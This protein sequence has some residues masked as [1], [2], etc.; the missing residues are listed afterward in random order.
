MRHR[1]TY[2]RRVANAIAAISESRRSRSPIANRD[3][4]PLAPPMA[5]LMDEDRCRVT[6]G[7]GVHVSLRRLRGAYTPRAPECRRYATSYQPPPLPSAPNVYPGLDVPATRAA[8]SANRSRVRWRIGIYRRTSLSPLFRKRLSLFEMLR[9]ARGGNVKRKGCS[10]EIFRA[11]SVGK[12]QFMLRVSLA[13][14]L[15]LSLLRSRIRS[16]RW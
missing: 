2:T 9:E 13:I 15:S 12:F 7:H 8:R 16:S 5:R 6:R 1:E 14:P 4:H 10:R 3:R 11:V